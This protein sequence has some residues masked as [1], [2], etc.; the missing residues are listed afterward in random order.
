[1][2][3][4]DVWEPMRVDFKENGEPDECWA[5]GS[6]ESAPLTRDDLGEEIVRPGSQ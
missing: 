2:P 4:G 3:D 1:M 5:I 6:D